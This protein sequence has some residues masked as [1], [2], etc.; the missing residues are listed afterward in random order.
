MWD[1]ACE[2][3]GS[4]SRSVS[5]PDLDIIRKELDSG[6]KL[7]AAA[8]EVATEIRHVSQITTIERFR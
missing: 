1:V 8:V 7:Y 6:R 3:K 2:I 4:I 5:G